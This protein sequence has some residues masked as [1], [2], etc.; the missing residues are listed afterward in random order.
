MVLLDESTKDIL[1]I[2][3]SDFEAVIGCMGAHKLST[4]ATEYVNLYQTLDAASPSFLEAPYGQAAIVF[5]KAHELMK[6]GGYLAE[7]TLD[8]LLLAVFPEPLS[9]IRWSLHT[10]QLANWSEELLGHALGEEVLIQVATPS[11]PSHA[12][13]EFSEALEILPRASPTVLGGFQDWGNSIKADSF[14]ASQG[15]R[16]LPGMPSR[17]VLQLPHAKGPE[18]VHCFNDARALMSTQGPELVHCFNDAGALMS[19]QTQ[20]RYQ[21]CRWRR[22]HYGPQ[23]QGP[24]WCIALGN[25]AGPR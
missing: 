15:P 20:D 14:S 9:A 1:P 4:D 7:A 10:I 24:N 21:G 5:M 19:T 17:E 13:P 22:L 6:Y 25:D 23:C 18:L 16:D 3:G 8:G 11:S 2:A 12:R